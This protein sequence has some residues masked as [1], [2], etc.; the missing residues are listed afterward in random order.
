MKAIHSVLLATLATATA[1]RQRRDA[2]QSGVAYPLN[3]V[4]QLTKDRTFP[5]QRDPTSDVPT[6]HHVIL[7][8]TLSADE[9]IVPVPTPRWTN[10][11]RAAVNDVRDFTASLINL[12]RNTTA[13]LTLFMDHRPSSFPANTNANIERINN[14]QFNLEDPRTV[15]GNPTAD[16]RYSDCSHFSMAGTSRALKRSPRSAVSLQAQLLAQV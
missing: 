7:F 12:F 3:G 4:S 16:D 2:F 10:A 9:R 13:Q 6:I 14:G 15:F 8:S 1:E 11:G 5:S